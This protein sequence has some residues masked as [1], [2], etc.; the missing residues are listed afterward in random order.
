MDLSRTLRPVNQTASNGMNRAFCPSGDELLP[1]TRPTPLRDIDHDDSELREQFERAGSRFAEETIPSEQ[2]P[3]ASVHRRLHQIAVRECLPAAI[4]RSVAVN[5]ETGQDGCEMHVHVGIKQPHERS[6]RA[7]ML[8]SRLRVKPQMERRSRRSHRSL[9]ETYR[10]PGIRGLKRQP[11]GYANGQFSAQE[12]GIGYDPPII[13]VGC[14]LPVWHRVHISILHSFG[15]AL[16]HGG[17]G[18]H[19]AFERDRGEQ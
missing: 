9:R 12:L 14:W 19:G 3:E 4:P 16:A 8:P 1:I 18:R 13:L 2:T 5:S 15:P 11:A 17:V 10:R 7:R 6:R